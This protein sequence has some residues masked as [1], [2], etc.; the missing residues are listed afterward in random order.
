MDMCGRKK[1]L[2]P[3]RRAPYFSV[4]PRG[5]FDFVFSDIV[6]TADPIS[7]AEPI[8]PICEIWTMTLASHVGLAGC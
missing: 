3:C 1:K 7:Q 2:L 4:Q 8:E 6:P 5:Q